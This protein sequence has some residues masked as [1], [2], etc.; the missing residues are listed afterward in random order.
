[1]ETR[2]LHAIP[3]PTCETKP[4][5]GALS[6]LCSLCFL[7]VATVLILTNTISDRRLK[8]GVCDLMLTLAI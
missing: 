3:H 5:H 2:L 7:V 6:V 8:S 1:M 4:C